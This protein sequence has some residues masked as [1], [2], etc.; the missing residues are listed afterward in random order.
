[1]DEETKEINIAVQRALDLGYD[2]TESVYAIFIKK[3]VRNVFYEI[4]T[5][6]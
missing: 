6:F 4:V 5:V 3:T 2:V 1:M